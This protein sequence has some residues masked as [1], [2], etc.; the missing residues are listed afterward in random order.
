MDRISYCVPS[1][2]SQATIKALRNMFATHGIPETIVSDNGSGFISCEFWDFTMKKGIQHIKTAP[3][4]P[5]S[6]GLAQASRK[7]CSDY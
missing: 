6:N 4:H 3:Y 1:T 7:S 5:A 2:S